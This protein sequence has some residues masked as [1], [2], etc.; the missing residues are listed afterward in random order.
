MWRRLYTLTWWLVLPLAFFYLWRRG[1]KQADYR[2][3][4]GERLGYYPAR[5]PRPLIWLHAVSVG[6]TRAAVG[7]V[8]ALRLR[9]PDHGIL[10]TQMT[11]TGRDT[12]RQLFGDEIEV[13]YLPYD[14]PGAVDRFLRHFRPTFG[15]L[16]EMELWPNLIHGAA[17]QGVPLFLINARLS[18]KSLRGYRKVARLLRPALAKLAGVA[19]QSA[20]DAERLAELGVAAPQVMGNLKFD[21]TPDPTQLAQGKV[22]R[23]RFGDRPVWLAAS[24]REGEEALLLAK[25]LPADGLLILVPRHPQRFDEVA[26]LLAQHQL[27]YV[28][29]SQWDGERPLPPGTQVL[30]GDSMG[31]MAAWFAAAD[32]AFVGGSLLDFGCHSVIE[33]CA[34]GVPVLVGPSSYNFAEAVSEAVS[35]GAAR[36][37][38]DVATL[39]TTLTALLADP[40][41]RDRMG[42]AGRAFVAAHRGALARAQEMLP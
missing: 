6:E 20:D 34:Q 24:T 30:L 8:R 39:M 23:E 21:F 27:A 37:L 13:A 9:H 19:A 41:E 18:A 32:V 36:Q 7:L 16:L 31:E 35:V 22:W 38:A 1:G 14:L 15:V 29:R 17:Q 26:N 25:P 10:L 28:R 5:S 33:P 4:W 12:A 11:P 2:R 40:A 3:N 42:E